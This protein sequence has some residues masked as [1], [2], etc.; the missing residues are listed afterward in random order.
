MH[1]NSTLVEVVIRI[2]DNF[3]ANRDVEY[4]A[5]ALVVTSDSISFLVQMG[6]V[7]NCFL[8]II[9]RRCRRLDTRMTLASLPFPSLPLQ[10]RLVGLVERF[11]QIVGLRRLVLTAV[12]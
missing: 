1:G 2:V 12:T 11:C 7:V 9:K 3:S 4:R 6:A 10:P 8:P 5:L